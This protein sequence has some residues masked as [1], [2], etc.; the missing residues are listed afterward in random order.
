MFFVHFSDIIQLQREAHLEQAALERKKFRKH[1]D[2]AKGASKDK[3]M[4]VIID[5]MTQNTTAL[6]RYRRKPSWQQQAHYDVHVQGVMIAGRQAKMEFAHCNISN[7]SNMAITSL[8]NAVLSEQKLRQAEGRPLPKVLYVQ[9]DNVNSNKSQLLMA[10]ASLLVKLNVFE[11]IKINFLLVGH[12][13]ENIDQLFSRLSVAL[14]QFDILCLEELMEIAKN[15]VQP[16]PTPVACQCSFD[17]HSFLKPCMNTVNDLSFNHAFRVL[18]VGNCT[19]LQSK[20]FGGFSRKSWES[21]QCEILTSIPEGDPS[22]VAPISM[23]DAEFN[24][25]TDLHAKVKAH[26]N[27]NRYSGKVKEYWDSQKSWQEHLRA[28]SDQTEPA[29]SFWHG[30]ITS[31]VKF[32]HLLPFT[33]KERDVFTRETA[34]ANLDPALAMRIAVPAR[35][36]YA[37]A[38][39]NKRKALVELAIENLFDVFDDINNFKIKENITQFV[40]AFAEEDDCSFRVPIGDGEKRILSDWLHFVKLENIDLSS[41]K[42]EWKWIVPVRF[43]TG[44]HKDQRVITKQLAEN[45]AQQPTWKWPVNP[46]KMFWDWNPAEY[47]ISWENLEDD[48]DLEIQ[49]E[50]YDQLVKVLTARAYKIAYSSTLELEA[51]PDSHTYE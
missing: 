4:C 17:W 10:Y 38:R 50:Q 24:E 30:F 2:K 49:P 51:L 32:E 11:K 19:V 13:H 1:W 6:P 15:S 39:A 29:L 14:R 16:S 34:L 31:E 9:L 44:V 25:F 43:S 27:E 21:V 5:G 42:V 41:R 48:R 12:T 47:V 20:Q 45:K 7:D 3:Y 22:I 40:I 35:P 28:D 26:T 8:H 46:P 23:K 36:I 37:G 33:F 18:N